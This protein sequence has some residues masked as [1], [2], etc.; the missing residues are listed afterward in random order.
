MK[1]LVALL[2]FLLLIAGARGAELR[3]AAASDLKFA[4]D[5]I[6]GA[7]TKSETGSPN[8]KTSYGASGNLF[9]QIQNGAP[10]DLFL[11]ADTN[12][13][14][15]LIES[16]HATNFFLYAEG[17]LAL[18]A[19]GSSRVSV[20]TLGLQALLDPRVRKIAI[21]NPAHA[22]YGRAA[23]AALKEAGI[24]DRITN[25]LVLGEN[26]AQA[27]QFVQSGGADIGIIALSLVRSTA[28]RDQGRHF[29]IPSALPQAGVV[30]L[31]GGNREAAEAFRKFL[32][33]P[34][35]RSILA[36]YGLAPK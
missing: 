12:Y 30:V 18:W 25:S 34:A 14:H 16:G 32:V 28:M 9:A 35:A 7:F 13:P 6:I 3:I 24:Y 33:S 22:P 15:R 29:A 23:V 21:A 10:F 4:L 17:H 8:V 20:E 31:R 5:E 26:V 2:G 19:P 27:A 36:R 1:R 11:S